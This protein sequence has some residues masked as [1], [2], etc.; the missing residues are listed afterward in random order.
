MIRRSSFLVFKLLL[1]ITLVCYCSLISTCNREQLTSVWAHSATNGRNDTRQPAA[2]GL[3][4]L[5]VLRKLTW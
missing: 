2:S 3:G 4:E 5:E 1:T